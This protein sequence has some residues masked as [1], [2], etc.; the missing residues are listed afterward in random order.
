MIDWNKPTAM[1]LG[2]WQPWH[3]GHQTLFEE[4]L[5]RTG[6]VIIMVRDMPKSDSNPFNFL[7]VRDNIK[8]ALKK[9]EGKFEVIKVPNIAN[10][11]YGRDVGYKVEK[12]DLDKEIESISATKIRAEMKEQ[13]KI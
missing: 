8:E 1:M 5:K 9:Y 11:I 13:R 4:A 2:R 10:I 7:Q 6:Q 12:I 3:K